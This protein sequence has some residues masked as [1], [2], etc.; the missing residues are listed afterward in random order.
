LDSSEVGPCLIEDQENNFL[1]LLNHLEY[2]GNTLSDEYLR[3]RDAEKNFQVPKNYFPNDDPKLDPINRWRSHAH[4]LYGNWV[5]E[6]Y[7][8]TPFDIEKIGLK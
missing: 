5:N 1:F 8:T 7:Q 2:D 4:L 6:I 3:D